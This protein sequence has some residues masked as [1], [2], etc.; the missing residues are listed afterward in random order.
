[1]LWVYA[2]SEGS[3]QTVYTCADPESFV[4]MGSNFDK[5]VLVEYLCIWYT[6]PS[7]LP[8]IARIGLRI[9]KRMQIPL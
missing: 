7:H 6:L 9:D 8:I 2:N 5:F 3:G 1:M 4:R